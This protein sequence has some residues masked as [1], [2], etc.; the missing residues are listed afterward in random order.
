M[1][2]CVLRSRGRG[3]SSLLANA[4]ASGHADV[5]LFGTWNLR[6]Y[7]AQKHLETH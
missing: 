6:L 5:G 2:V 1:G 3:I 7:W 4:E